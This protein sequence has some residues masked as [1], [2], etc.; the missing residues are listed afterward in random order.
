MTPVHEA[1]LPDG[2]VLS[3]HRARL[4]LGAVHEWLAGSA[5]WATGRTPEQTE[6]SWAHCHPFG[7]YAPGAELAG[8]ARVLTDY[9]FRA[10]LADLFILPGRRG[11]GLGKAL[12]EFVLGHPSLRTVPHWTLTTRDAHALYAR[13]GFRLGEA[14]GTSMVL[15]RTTT[16]APDTGNV[17]AP[18]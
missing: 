11:R 5:Y 4:D 13:H 7:A 9:T 18:R 12:V 8:F 14:D 1:V 6:R 17:Q 3:D 2:H 15:H 10:H 16:L